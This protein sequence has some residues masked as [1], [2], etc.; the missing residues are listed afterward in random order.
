MNGAVWKAL[1]RSNWRIAA[2]FRGFWVPQN[3]PLGVTIIPWLECDRH[4]KSGIA[5]NPDGGN[6]RR[7]AS[8]QIVKMGI[9]QFSP[10]TRVRVGCTWI[11]IGILLKGIPAKV[12]FFQVSCPVRNLGTCSSAAEALVQRYG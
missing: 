2:F 6:R 10:T 9:Q 5:K 7:C 1:G 12:T 3:S 4:F 11:Q 8:E